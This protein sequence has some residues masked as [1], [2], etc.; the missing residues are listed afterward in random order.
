MKHTE[1]PKIV[2]VLFLCLW[3]YAGASFYACAAINPRSPEAAE[4]MVQGETPDSRAEYRVLLAAYDAAETPQ[5]K[6]DAEAALVAYEDD[7]ARR[8]GEEAGTVGGGILGVVIPGLGPLGAVLGGAIA[9]QA[10]PAVLTPRGRRLLRQAAKQLGPSTP[11]APGAMAVGDAIK[12]LFVAAG[13][14][15]SRP[16][17]D[18]PADP[19][20]APAE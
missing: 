19:A 7:M 5:E 18:A 6:A 20:T 13:W 11:D 12:T 3:A 9:G 14:G 8:K 1:T 2:R 16:D 17:P 10:A 15:D 4:T